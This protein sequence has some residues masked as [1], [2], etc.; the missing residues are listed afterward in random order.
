VVFVGG[1]LLVVL[2]RPAL[3]AEDTEQVVSSGV[4]AIIEGDLAK[5]RDDALQDALRS[6]VEQAV[7]TMISSETQVENFQTLED[8]IYTQTRGYIQKYDVVSEGKR[9]DG[10]IY[11]VKVKAVVKTGMVK[12]DLEAL[13]ILMR[14]KGKP[15]IM[16][17]MPE[18]HLAGSGAEKEG[19]KKGEA[20]SAG[21]PAG[22]TEMIRAF[23]EKGFAVVDQS[24][25]R[26][27]R[28]SEQARAAVEGDAKAA[29]AIGRQFGAE[30]II[31]GQS[32]SEFGTA[33]GLGGM[34]S[35]QARSEGRAI[36]CDTGEILYAAGKDA[37]GLDLSQVLAGK[38]ALTT[39]GGQLAQVMIEQIVER[40]SKEVASGTSVTL[41]IQGLASYG[42]L[43]DFLSSLKLAVRGVKEVYPREFDGGV[44]VVEVE[45]STDANR[46]AGELAKKKLGSFSVDVTGK[47]QNKL[48]LKVM[49]K[50]G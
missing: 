27:I 5:A 36:N 38:K 33:Q 43:T 12:D 29:A 3:P 10:L 46:L 13:G 44:A 48:T 2:A 47:T 50:K 31:V 30:V 28:E 35:S 26:K 14:R 34:V 8:K 41:N 11:E 21:E 42:E 45:T 24:Q 39:A 32:F 7:G 49:K 25:V 23:I 19:G 37:A 18:S 22:E 9:D 40:W 16:I 1:L 6:A 4:G 15:R 20:W 17:V